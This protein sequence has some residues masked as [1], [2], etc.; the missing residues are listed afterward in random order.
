LFYKE[1]EIE[2]TA[3]EIKNRLG[4]KFSKWEKNIDIKKQ[5]LSGKG[6]EKEKY[7]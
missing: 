2:H 1:I 7:K 6:I 5:R 3:K 4:I